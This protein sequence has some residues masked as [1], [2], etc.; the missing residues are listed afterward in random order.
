ML[1]P[2][3]W[4]TVTGLVVGLAA[5]IELSRDRRVLAPG[6]R[7]NANIRTAPE[8]ERCW[9]GAEVWRDLCVRE[10][11]PRHRLRAARPRA[12]TNEAEIIRRMP[13]RM[14]RRG[15]GREGGDEVLTP[16]TCAAFGIRPDGTADTDVDHVVAWAEALDSGLAP[17]L[18]RDFVDD[19]RN[20]AL[21]DPGVNSGIKRDRDAAG[22][23]PEHNHLW[24]A[25]TVLLVKRRYGLAVDRRERDALEAILQDERGRDR[26]TG[27]ADPDCRG[28]GSGG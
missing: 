21:A 9:D 12:R 16:Y 13:E 19:G 20:H 7:G 23:L 5:G 18:Y 2:A 8:P 17:S 14:K 3:A 24:F 15:T 11:R 26:W 1:R 10:E 27:R 28:T 4:L 6:E 22:W 25:E